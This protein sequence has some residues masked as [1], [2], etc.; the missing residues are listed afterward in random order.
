VVG[1]LLRYGVVEKLALDERKL[2]ASD[3]DTI[4]SILE[5]P[6]REDCL[7]MLWKQWWSRPCEALYSDEVRYEHMKDPEALLNDADEVLGFM[8]ENGG[9]VDENSDE[10]VVDVFVVGYG[11]CSISSSHMARVKEATQAASLVPEK[12]TAL[13]SLSICTHANDRDGFSRLFGLEDPGEATL[14]RLL[15]LVC[16]QLEELVIQADQLRIGL[17]FLQQIL[18]LCPN[19]RQLSIQHLLLDQVDDQENVPEP[20]GQR[21]PLEVLRLD[22]QMDEQSS[23][24]QALSKWL[25]WFGVELRE[26][27]LRTRNPHRPVGDAALIAIEAMV[28]TCCRSCEKI[29]LKN[30]AVDYFRHIFAQDTVSFPRLG[31]LVFDGALWTSESLLAMLSALSSPTHPL[32]RSLH[33][34]AISIDHFGDRGDER[35]AEMLENNQWLVN[36]RFVTRGLRTTRMAE[37]N[38][39]ALKRQKT[40]LTLRQKAAL[41][42]VLET[43]KMPWESFVITKIF[44]FAIEPEI[45][46]VVVV[47]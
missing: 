14:L 2:I 10:R 39:I 29:K 45:R 37:T 13:K 28:Q 34:L 9:E 12:R 17:S 6:A 7:R 18:T 1:Y 8:N 19:L 3:L 47:L 20:A 44:R 15:S 33:T 46:R 21:H 4:A 31:T 35:M 22:L 23:G 43:T 32:T 36:F 40:P 41:L 5:A 11:Q 16:A 27:H 38:G 42:S 26:L 24:V 25:V 30:F